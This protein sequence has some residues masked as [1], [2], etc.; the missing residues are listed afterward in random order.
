M[1]DLLP[2]LRG[3]DGPA[4][5][6]NGPQFNDHGHAL[7]ADVIGHWMQSRFSNLIA[8]AAHGPR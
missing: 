8:A 7:A 5:E 4:F 6:R 3:E 1:I 2:Y